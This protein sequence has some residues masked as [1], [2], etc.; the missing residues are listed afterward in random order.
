MC[1]HCIGDSSRCYNIA[2]SVVVVIEVVAAVRIVAVVFLMKTSR[3]KSNSCRKALLLEIMVC[4]NGRS[5]SNEG[6]GF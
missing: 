4:S 1:F 2:I 6:V 5:S 3:G